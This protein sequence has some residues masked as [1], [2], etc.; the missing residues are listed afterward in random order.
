V[1]YNTYIRGDLDLSGNLELSGNLTAYQLLDTSGL[2]VNYNSY[3]RGDL[4]LSGNLEL[5]GNLTTYQLLDTSGL[6]VEHN[7]FIKGNLDVSGNL[8]VSGNTTLYGT[9]DSRI[10][11]STPTVTSTSLTIS[12]NPYSTIYII[13]NSTYDPVTIDTTTTPYY[14]NMVGTTSYFVPTT[15]GVTPP[16]GILLTYNGFGGTPYT[17]G[18]PIPVPGM[19]TMLCVGSD[20]STKNYFST[21]P[22]A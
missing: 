3:I 5:S 16:T 13:D 18:V 15:A 22:F 20:G 1:N 14:P 19:I 7:T 4:D 2:R 9:L 21:Y 6:Q 10:P 11:I 8:E 12:L 17:M